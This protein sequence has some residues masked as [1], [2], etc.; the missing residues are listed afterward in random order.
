MTTLPEGDVLVPEE[1]RCSVEKDTDKLCDVWRY[2]NHFHT[3]DSGPEVEPVGD[4]EHEKEEQDLRLGILVRPER[5][6][7]VPDKA[8]YETACIADDV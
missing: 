2:S 8:V 5:P 6:S 7:P 4:P 1:V 3:E